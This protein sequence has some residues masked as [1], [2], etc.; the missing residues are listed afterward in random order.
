MARW[1][2]ARVDVIG[3]IADEVLHN[4]RRGRAIVGVDGIP[5]AG[6]SRFADDL[7]SALVDR[8]AVA[9]RASVDSAADA[10]GET[11]RAQQIEPFRRGDDPFA[12]HGDAILVIDG[13]RLHG[14]DLIPVFVYTVWLSRPGL[15]LGPDDGQDRYEK[16][17]APRVRA[18]AN[19]DATDPEHP[20][21][22]FADS[23]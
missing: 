16:R 7:A 2:P 13:T 17:A 4:Y 5:G 11:L 18:T 21:R 19:I 6:Q 3:E 1:V 8:G 22:T 10:R 14:P 20:R 23:C 9:Y 15:E 12:D